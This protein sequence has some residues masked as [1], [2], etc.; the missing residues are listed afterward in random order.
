MKSDKIYIRSL[1]PFFMQMYKKVFIFEKPEIPVFHRVDPEI[2]N[3]QFEAGI[4]GSRDSGFRDANPSM[5]VSVLR[6]LPSSRVLE[7]EFWRVLLS[8]R[9]CYGYF[10]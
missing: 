4:P 9:S 6:L 10:A 5:H 7:T 1:L 3:K 8:K 2:K